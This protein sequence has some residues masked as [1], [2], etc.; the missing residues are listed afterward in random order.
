MLLNVYRLS[1]IL[2]PVPYILVP[3]RE[4]NDRSILTFWSKFHRGEQQRGTYAQIW[5][6]FQPCDSDDDENDELYDILDAYEEP[7]P[8][9]PNTAAEKTTK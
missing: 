4:A 7:D 9:T 3:V 8:T 5:V 6:Y 1:Y 2:V